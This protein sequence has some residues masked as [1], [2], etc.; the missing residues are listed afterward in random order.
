MSGT[1]VV[2]ILERA[3][4]AVIA[5]RT[6]SG[7]S[8][9]NSRSA[10]GGLDA[11]LVIPQD[12]VPFVMDLAHFRGAGAADLPRNVDLF[13]AYVNGLTAEYLESRVRAEARH[14]AERAK[15]CAVSGR[16][17]EAERAQHRA[18][19]LMEIKIGDSA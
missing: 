2:E 16:E 14:W 5:A 19:L 10:P 9:V 12:R 6:R 3:Q 7:C 1:T 8:F 11:V 13:C 4:R 17:H 15:V 18:A